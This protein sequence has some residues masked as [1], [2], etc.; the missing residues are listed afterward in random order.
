LGAAVKYGLGW[1][2]PLTGHVV[3]QTVV[4]D[5]AAATEAEFRPVFGPFEFG[6]KW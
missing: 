5:L 6:G 1:A 2:S 3:T 4:V